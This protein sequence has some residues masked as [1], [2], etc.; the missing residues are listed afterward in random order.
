MTITMQMKNLVA[1][2][3]INLPAVKSRRSFGSGMEWLKLPVKLRD[4]MGTI[5]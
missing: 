2:L 1:Q 4:V 3:A 5:I